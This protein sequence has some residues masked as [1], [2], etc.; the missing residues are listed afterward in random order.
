MPSSTATCP[1]G[2]LILLQ[3]RIATG[4]P[5]AA[6]SLIEHSGYLR[7]STILPDDPLLH[8]Y[9]ISCLDAGRN[10]PIIAL[11]DRFQVISDIPVTLLLFI[12]KAHVHSNKLKKAQKLIEDWLIM[13]PDSFYTKFQT[14]NHNSKQ[15]AMQHRHEYTLL[16]EC[17]VCECLKDS[18]EALAFLSANSLLSDEDRLDL[19]SRVNQMRSQKTSLSNTAAS[20]KNSEQVHSTNNAETTVIQDTPNTP[21]LPKEE[22][23]ND[24]N[25]VERVQRWG[26]R[27]IQQLKQL[28]QSPQFIKFLKMLA[29]PFLLGILWTTLQMTVLYLQQKN[30][31]STTNNNKRGLLYWLMRLVRTL[32]V[33]VSFI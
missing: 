30:G 17:Y 3:H 20:Q 8:L 29:P 4:K 6:V 19:I 9:A 1:E 16:I 25:T 28:L 32:N 27:T 22:T 11:L 18:D 26:E 24:K 10:D 33:A 2:F 13:Q 15:E 31:Q 7:S 14:S 5:D 23:K 12:V 21:S